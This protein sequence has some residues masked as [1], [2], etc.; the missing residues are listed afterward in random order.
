VEYRLADG[1]LQGQKERALPPGQSRYEP[2][3]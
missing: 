1:K 2:P 3:E